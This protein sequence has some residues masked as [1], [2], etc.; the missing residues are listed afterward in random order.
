[1]L[2]L[3]SALD[4][5]RYRSRDGRLLL[6]P[7]LLFLK[8]EAPRQPNSPS[9]LG[10]VKRSNFLSVSLNY[11]GTFVLSIGL[12]KRRKKVRPFNMDSL[13]NLYLH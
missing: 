7:V 2:I 5:R 13:V 12:S 6:L 3:E 11:N 4:L 8:M 9:F 1:M 10:E